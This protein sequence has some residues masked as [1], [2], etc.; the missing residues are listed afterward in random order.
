MNA[1]SIIR[2]LLAALAGVAGCAAGH[3]GTA[4][5]LLPPAGPAAAAPPP[6]PRIVQYRNAPRSP[7]EI[8]SDGAGHQWFSECDKTIAAIDESSGKVTQY[9]TSLASSC[10]GVA[11]GR[12]GTPNVVH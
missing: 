9:D 3:Q 4:T 11:A 2:G 6:A 1:I 5:P 10:G 8:A 7:W 12:H